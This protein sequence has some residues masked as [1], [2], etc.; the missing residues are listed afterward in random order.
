MNLINLQANC[1]YNVNVLRAKTTSNKE[2]RM[3]VQ[4]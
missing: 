1:R 2:S 3:K 4:T